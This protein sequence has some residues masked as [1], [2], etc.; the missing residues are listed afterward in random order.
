MSLGLSASAWRHCQH[1]GGEGLVLGSVLEAA[2]RQCAIVCLSGD[3]LCGPYVGR[4][5]L[6]SSGIFY[7]KGGRA[8]WVSLLGDQDH[9]P[10]P[11]SPQ[12]QGAHI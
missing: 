11:A 3:G 5:L 7:G 1:R 9:L 2:T 12:Q 4:C 8:L 10:H 6:N